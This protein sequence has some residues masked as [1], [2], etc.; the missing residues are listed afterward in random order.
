MGSRALSPLLGT[1]LLVVLSVLLAA[2]M[3]T[4]FGGAGIESTTTARFS[5]SADAA[6]DQISLTH[7][8][9]AALNSNALEIHVEVD[10]T[11]LEHQPPVPFF[12]A[13]G[14]VSGPTGPFNN[15]TTDEWIAGETG[16]FRLARTNT[17]PLTDGA[18]VEITITRDGTVLGTVETSA[19]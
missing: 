10:G 5:A 8:G 12:A 19:E 9:G 15:A 11:P 1:V 6:N 7:E 14:F 16:S 3:G 18:S 2:T 13:S 17:P 4:V